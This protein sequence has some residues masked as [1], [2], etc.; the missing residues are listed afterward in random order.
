MEG[1]FA[2]CTR[3]RETTS[4]SGKAGSSEQDAGPQKGRH[5]SNDH[6][7]QQ[8]SS[9]KIPKRKLSDCG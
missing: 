5:N 9:A 1:W 3:W 2:S 4:S 8:V 6:A 7:K